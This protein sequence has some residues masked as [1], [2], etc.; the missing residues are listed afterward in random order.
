MNT[1]KKITLFIKQNDAIYNA[2][3]AKSIV[4][5]RKDINNVS[6]DEDKL[7]LLIEE[8]EELKSLL[9]NMYTHKKERNIHVEN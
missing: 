3:I 6:N 8:N 1:D 5:T 9:L 2:L 7:K 4:F